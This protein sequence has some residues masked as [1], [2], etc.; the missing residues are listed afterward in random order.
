[1]DLNMFLFEIL[2]AKQPAQ[3]Q[4]DPQEQTPQLEQPAEPTPKKPSLI[5]QQMKYLR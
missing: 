1:M 4:P 5:K 2:E 3:E